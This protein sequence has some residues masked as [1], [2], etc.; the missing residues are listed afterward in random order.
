MQ[1][2]L[3]GPI[4]VFSER[5]RL[6]LGQPKQRAVLACLLL[7]RGR[8]ASREELIEALWGQRPPQSA[9]GSL[10]VYIHGLRRVLGA[11][12]IEGQGSAYR[13]R[14]QAGE[15]DLERFEE[16]VE[17][18]RD[19]LV[20]GHAQ[21]AASALEAAL[22][23]WSGPA[24]GDLPPETLAAERTQIEE[25]RLTALELLI[26]AHLA[27]GEH[28]Q[29]IAL[30]STLIAEHPYRERLREHQILAL[31]RAGRQKDA[32]EAYR[33]A[34]GMLVEELG[35]EPG[36]RLRALEAAI[37][38]QEPTLTAPAS[39][40]N[41]PDTNVRARPE[42]ALPAPPTRLIGRER[43]LAEVDALFSEDGARLVT[44]TG[45]GG[46]GKTR[47][48]LAV[49]ERL[50]TRAPDGARFIDLS[51]T[52]DPALV[53]PMIAEGLEVAAGPSLLESIAAQLRPLRMLLVLDN[54][55]RLLDAATPLSELL[56]RAP[57]LLMLA[58]SRAPLRIRAE[59]EY[60]VPPLALPDVGARWEL[61]AQSEAVQL[62]VARARAVNR[63]CVLTESSAAAF[64]HICRRLD[65]LPLA[66]ELAASRMRTLSVD[67]VAAG[68]DRALDLLVE[69]PRDLPVR[70][71]TLRATLEWSHEQ[72]G[73]S[74]Q[75][76][77][78]QLA[79]FS[80][81]FYVDDV[82]ALFGDEAREPLNSLIEVSL[83]RQI[84]PERLTML[85]TIREYAAERLAQSGADDSVRRRHC[86][87]FLALAERTHEAILRGEEPVTAFRA[88]EQAHDN[89][90][91][92]LTW[93]AQTGEVE[94]EVRLACALR[95]FWL[96]RGHLAE[97]RTF[98]QRAVAITAGADPRLRAQSLMNG[99]PFLYRQGELAQARA[100][101]EEALAL[102]TDHGDVA[103]ASRCAGELGAVAFSEGDLGRSA[104]LYAHAAAG[105]ES[106]GDRMRLGI[107]RGN[108]AEISGLQGDLPR[109]LEHAEESVALA[110]EIG[111]ADSLALSLHTLGR[112]VRKTSDAERARH[113]FGECL[114][115][116]RDLGY[117]EVLANCVQAAA[118]RSL[119][120][121]GDP[122]VAAR[123]QTIARQAMQE[124]GVRPQGLERQS[125]D[126]TDAVLAKRLDPER[127]R[128][129]EQAAADLGLESALDDA[130]EVL[131]PE[132][133]VIG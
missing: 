19:A 99:G 47:L 105:F 25:L 79:A 117:R 126:H 11:E 86:K 83:V 18:A 4:Q 73:A 115:L 61:I 45:P 31:Y 35:I 91:E 116:A 65:G 95:Q 5:A 76:L 3:L 6:S 112:L 133:S 96:V 17:Q 90:R 39:G 85:E 64:A 129:I 81:S 68:L 32:L 120:A 123:F 57:G 122:V 111:D 62:L 41:G 124:M 16:L 14:L 1:Y 60:R 30:V 98:F 114:V 27:E 22:A 77:F 118:E 93:A 23:L 8:F 130:L 50:A 13:I 44:L 53:L 106:L 78:A 43:E 52:P 103:G 97:G 113:L 58:T 48:A 12:R 56:I 46:A 71:R 9:T 59:H 26:E 84:E 108:Q 24:L 28:E 37:L 38:R 100:W 127:L 21:R 34:R 125:F 87:H 7:R 69:G 74:E 36:P 42:P 110:R 63:S 51:A 119:S 128:A 72:L 75:R 89:L 104:E 80:G 70:Q 92:A 132:R 88:L 40:P 121:D 2:R 55:E 15:L 20:G 10:H 29:V 94:L 66:L 102:F 109:A 67:G 49:A 101:W 82:A 54:L 33:R 131:Q 107:V